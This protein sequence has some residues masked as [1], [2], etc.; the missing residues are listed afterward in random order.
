MIL[1]NKDFPFLESLLYK[2]IIIYNE[3]P[4]QIPIETFYE[5]NININ[6]K[7]LEAILIFLYC[8][9]KIEI[10]ENELIKL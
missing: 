5:S 2:S 8:I 10:K 6:S 3:L 4:S 9:K 1:P 7:D